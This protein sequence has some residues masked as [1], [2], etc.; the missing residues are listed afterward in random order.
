MVLGG[1]TK[2]R[3]GL[4]EDIFYISVIFIGGRL[5]ISVVFAKS[6]MPVTVKNTKLVKGLSSEKWGEKGAKDGCLIAL[7]TRTEHRT[8]LWTKMT[9]VD[10]EIRAELTDPAPSPFSSFSPYFTSESKFLTTVS[11]F[12][13]PSKLCFHSALQLF[14][15]CMPGNLEGETISWRN[16]RIYLFLQINK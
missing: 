7:D 13:V 12:E 3:N 6:W 2:V 5:I 8:V 10:W 14:I 16:S 11:M 9:C 1:T 4:W 15:L